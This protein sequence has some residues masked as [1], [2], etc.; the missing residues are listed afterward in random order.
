MRSVAKRFDFV[1]DVCPTPPRMLPRLRHMPASFH[2][3]KKHIKS[4]LCESVVTNTPCEAGQNCPHIHCSQDGYQTRRDWILSADR[5]TSSPHK[6][7][8]DSEVSSGL[9]GD[10]VADSGVAPSVAETHPKVALQLDACHETRR[11][12][13]G[14]SD[15][16]GAVPDEHAYC[17]I[18]PQGHLDACNGTRHRRV[19]LP[20]LV[21][22]QPFQ[23][24][25]YSL[26]P[27]TSPH[28]GEEPSA[29]WSHGGSSEDNYHG[30]PH[31]FTPLELPE[32][33][34]V[35]CIFRRVSTP[36]RAGRHCYCHAPH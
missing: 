16:F 32:P 17:P 30:A 8:V 23:N 1:V 20:P 4:W 3:H 9:F 2:R 18:A 27:T 29:G 12:L 21:P 15:A 34:A 22:R 28:H 7:A 36:R 31:Q 10:D 19:A 11:P 35:C 13:P 25:P 26:P 5:S 6:S 33:F 24:D 14:L